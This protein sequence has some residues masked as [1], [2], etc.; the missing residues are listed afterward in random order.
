MPPATDKLEVLVRREGERT[1]LCAPE[2]GWFTRALP[3][4]T[5]VGHGTA[6][7]VIA[8]LGRAR[9][10]VLPAGV[11][12]RIVSRRPERVHEPVGWG[13]TLYELAPIEAAGG[14]EAAAEA[15]A[16][17][18]DGAVFR[19]PYSGRFWQRPAPQDPPFVR[20]GDRIAVGQTVGL[21]EVMKTFTHL[22]YTADGGLP[23]SARIVRVLAGDG[24]EVSED[25]P[26]IEVEAG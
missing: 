13:T 11:A 1:L 15:A 3:R 4:N 18:A 16:A 8:T 23:E 19:A 14:A 25:D 26:L 9:E 2:V 12:G 6:V 17:S 24:D 20:A 5:P 7:G 22:A 10:L 21:I